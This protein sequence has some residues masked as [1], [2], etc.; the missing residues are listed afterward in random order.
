[1]THIG[2]KIKELRK[3]KDITQEKTCRLSQR[4]IPGGFKMGDWSLGSGPF[5]A[6]QACGLLWCQLRFSSWYSA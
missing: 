6:H 2:M 4:V 3:K 1:M 5:Y